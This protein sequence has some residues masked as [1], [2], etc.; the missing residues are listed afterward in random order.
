[1]K[2]IQIERM[3]KC[4]ID[5]ANIYIFDILNNKQSEY[6]DNILKNYK[7]GIEKLVSNWSG[8]KKSKKELKK[9][10]AYLKIAKNTF[11]QQ[12]AQILANQFW[13]PLFDLIQ[14]VSIISFLYFAPI[15]F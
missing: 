13:S 6:I 12:K 14:K 1:M 7:N 3:N 11:D 9:Y 10:E 15:S 5:N 8:I 4:N 2:Y